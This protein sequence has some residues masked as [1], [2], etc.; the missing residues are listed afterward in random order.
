MVIVKLFGLC[1]ALVLRQCIVAFVL[2]G[3]RL[4]LLVHHCV[5]YK[6]LL[7]HIDVDVNIDVQVEMIESVASSVLAT[8][9]LLT[10]IDLRPVSN[11]SISFLI[12]QLLLP[13]L[14]LLLQH[15]SL[16]LCH[17]DLMEADRGVL[18]VLG[19][20]MLLVAQVVKDLL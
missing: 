18:I 4:A 11:L 19:V 12:L 7:V 1:H 2:L 10:G 8:L 15:F 14:T 13:L 6:S 16:L 20:K 9:R 17:L 3:W 5:V